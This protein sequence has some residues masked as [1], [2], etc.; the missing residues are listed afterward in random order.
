MLKTNER[1]SPEIESLRGLAALMVAG[2]HSFQYW[3]AFRQ[4]E[5]AKI[6]NL[7]FDF[8]VGAGASAVTLFFVISGFVLMGSMDRMKDTNLLPMFAEFTWKRV[9]RIYPAIVII[10][11]VFALISPGVFLN[12]ESFP[13]WERT[14]KNAALWS[15]DLISPTWSTRIEVAATPIFFVGW[16][17]RKHGMFLLIALGTILAALAFAPRLYAGDL[18]GK[19][20]FVFTFG[21]LLPD[22]RSLFARLP[23][24]LSPLLFILAVVV[25]VRSRIGAPEWHAEPAILREAICGVLVVGLVAFERLSWLRTVLLTAPIRYFG[26]ISFSF[27]ILHFPIVL[28]LIRHLPGRVV[29]NSTGGNATLAGFEIWL[30]TLAITVPLSSLTWAYIEKPG[31]ALGKL[32][33]RKL[34]RTV[35]T[36]AI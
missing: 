14:L 32:V 3:F 13:G 15:S 29:T 2:L 23:A 28:M 1:F 27:Y 36:P 11:V 10:T 18:I 12:S 9:A 35:P 30:L 33:I 17:A 8:F 19:Y 6:P 5:A 25:S 21:M 16:I 7:V 20:L 4:P 26:R 22:L 34:Q 31:V 24:L